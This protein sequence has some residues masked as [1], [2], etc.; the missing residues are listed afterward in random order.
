[1]C[2]NNTKANFYQALSYHLIDKMK[3]WEE[4]IAGVLKRAT[5]QGVVTCV[6]IGEFK[7]FKI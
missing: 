3:K 1:M 6:C 2:E 7:E 5:F 4:Y